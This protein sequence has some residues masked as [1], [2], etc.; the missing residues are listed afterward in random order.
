MASA[1]V[2]HGG[3][4]RLCGS[5]CAALASNESEMRDFCGTPDYISSEMARSAAAPW[6][7][8]PEFAAY[9]ALP[10]QSHGIATDVWS[11][12]VTVYELVVGT[13]PFSDVVTTA[14]TQFV[15]LAVAIAGVDK[16]PFLPVWVR[17]PGCSLWN[18]SIAY[19]SMQ[20]RIPTCRRS[21]KSI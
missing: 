1:L 4:V 14:T 8:H 20:M 18:R 6:R 10:P 12:G 9:A 3:I 16:P 7:S 21:V 13:R 2:G 17:W 5:G 15:E 19:H 11:L